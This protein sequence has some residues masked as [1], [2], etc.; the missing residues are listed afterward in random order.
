MLE[1]TNKSF[2]LFASVCLPFVTVCLTGTLYISVEPVGVAGVS[3]Y[4]SLGDYLLSVTF[5]SSQPVV[6]AKAGQ[7][8]AVNQ[9]HAAL[10]SSSI[11]ACAAH[12][13]L[14]PKPVVAG[15]VGGSR[16]ASSSST[17]LSCQ[18]P[19][20]RALSFS[21]KSCS[22]AAAGAVVLLNFTI[23]S[24]PACF[25]GSII[26]AAPQLEPLAAAGGG[27]SEACPCRQSPRRPAHRLPL[28]A[29]GVSGAVPADGSY[30]CQQGVYSYGWQLPHVSAGCHRLRVTLA[31]G[32][33][34][35]A[36][37]RVVAVSA[38][39]DAVV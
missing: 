6:M 24:P 15:A 9:P 31:D 25:E 1:D 16:S 10:A 18:Y 32:S 13:G 3:S 35:L 11:V 27:A 33:N 37:L 23:S 28:A 12:K 30:T 19:E 21:A 4:G 39:A 26:A 14:V 20:V 17:A 5:P 34:V 7:A 36:V 29:Q 8:A 2:A 22:T 38:S